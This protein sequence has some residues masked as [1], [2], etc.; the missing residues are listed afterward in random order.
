LTPRLMPL[1]Y[2]IRAKEVEKVSKDMGTAR[3]LIEKAEKRM[4]F[5]KSIKI[6]DD[7]ASFVFEEIYT[8]IRECAQCL[9][10]ADGYKSKSSHEAAIAFIADKYREFGEKLVVDFDRYR[11]MRNDSVYRDN[12]VSADVAAEAMGIAEEYIRITRLIF[13]SKV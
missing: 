10:I 9:M 2:Y 12:Y 1:E 5:V 6:T 4:R 7:N 3:S 13:N 11:K 8:V